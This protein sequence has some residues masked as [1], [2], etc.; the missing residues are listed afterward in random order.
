[1]DFVVFEQKVQYFVSLIDRYTK[2]HWNGN[3]WWACAVHVRALS[4]I[5]FYNLKKKFKTEQIESILTGATMKKKILLNE[6]FIVE[7]K[8]KNNEDRHHND[9]GNDQQHRTSF[10]LLSSVSL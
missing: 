6:I 3:T 1:M 5:L 4:K 8:E 2:T 9:T 7:D 10:G